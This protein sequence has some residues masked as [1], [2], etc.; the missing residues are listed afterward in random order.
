VDHK[1][2]EKAGVGK[3]VAMKIVST[4]PS[5]AMR[6]YVMDSP[7]G[8]VERS[9]SEVSV[10]VLTWS[11]RWWFEGKGVSTARLTPPASSL[12]VSLSLRYGRHFDHTDEL[13]SHISRT[14]ID[15]VKEFFR[16]ELSKDDWL[17]MVKLKKLFEIV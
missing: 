4:A 9:P 5:E 15:L 14:S 13:V 3:N 17:L 11:H 8:N 6:M 7:L 10:G 16:D 12:S 2:V 1:S